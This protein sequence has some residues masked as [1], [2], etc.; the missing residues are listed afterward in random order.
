M[1]GSQVQPPVGFAEQVTSDPFRVFANHLVVN[2]FE[3]VELNRVA[4]PVRGLHAVDDQTASSPDE[5]AV[6]KPDCGL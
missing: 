5:V 3:Q 2:V 4:R 1:L 6:Q